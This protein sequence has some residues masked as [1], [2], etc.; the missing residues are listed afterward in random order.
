MCGAIP[1]GKG[2]RQKPAC[3][4]GSSPHR[5]A[6]NYH[7]ARDLVRWRATKSQWGHPMKC[8]ETCRFWERYGK[9]ERGECNLATTHDGEPDCPGAAM[10]ARDYDM[11]AAWLETKQDHYC[12]AW[13]E[14]E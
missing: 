7:V 14:R 8:C 2:T 11:Y 4:C 3:Y 1:V 13:E 10:R 9:T 12:A 6:H 5:P